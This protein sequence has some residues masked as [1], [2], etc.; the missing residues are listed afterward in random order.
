MSQRLRLD[1]LCEEDATTVATREAK[2]LAFKA[3]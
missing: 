1:S 3:A 2:A